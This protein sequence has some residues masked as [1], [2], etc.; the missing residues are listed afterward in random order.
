MI[1][2]STSSSGQRDIHKALDFF[3]DI[4]INNIEIGAFHK[5]V[6]DLNKIIQFKKE[7]NTN[8]T[9]HAFFPPSTPPMML[10][11]GSDDPELLKKYISFSKNSLEFCRKID[12]LMYSIHTGY[13][14]EVD[15]MAM[16]KEGKKSSNETI[17][18]NTKNSIIELA[19]YADSYGLKIAFENH[20]S[21]DREMYF[22]RPE[23]LL[24]LHKA[25]GKKNAG[26]L[27]DLGHLNIASNKLN[28]NLKEALEKM[29]DHIFQFHIH[30][31]EGDWDNHLPLPN[32]ELVSNIPKRLKDRLFVIEG[33][34][35]TK[36]E[37]NNSKNIL[38]SVLL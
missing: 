9:V 16:P 11:F 32:K 34:A 14:C 5:P 1:L 4:N 21:M 7:N 18:N 15:H 27:L 23:D 29:K 2:V 30:Y 19:E 31:N 10:N 38:E 36:E 20:S 6:G 17:F 13:E 22:S 26:F 3:K 12:A 24:K 25:I 8:F 33:K 37:I 28:F 35:W